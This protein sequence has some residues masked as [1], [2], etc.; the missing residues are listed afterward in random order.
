MRKAWTRLQAWLRREAYVRAM[1]TE[2]AKNGYLE[3]HAAGLAVGQQAGYQMG[4]A[5][6]ELI[7]RQKLAQEVEARFGLD[8]R[9]EMQAEDA[10]RIRVS[11]L[12]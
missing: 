10:L 4:L 12:H 5:Y 6:G 3:G 9:N 8:N 1:V 7:G 11:Q 2:A